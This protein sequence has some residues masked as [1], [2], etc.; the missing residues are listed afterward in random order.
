MAIWNGWRL[1]A[2]L[3]RCQCFVFELKESSEGL[4][5]KRKTIDAIQTCYWALPICVAT[6]RIDVGKSTVSTHATQKQSLLPE[7]AGNF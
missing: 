3:T 6:A 1:T 7:I 5:I 4:P 2:D